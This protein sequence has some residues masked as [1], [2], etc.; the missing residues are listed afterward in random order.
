MK[1]GIITD[2]HSNIQA[3]NAVLNEFDKIKV[4]KIICCG[5]IIGIGINPE[6]TVQTLMKKKDM[7]IMVVG[8]HE[9]YL[10]NGLPETVHDDKRKLSDEEIANHLWNEGKLSEESKRF[11]S[12]LDL[13]K[14]VEIEGKKFY[15]VHYPMNDDGTYKKLIKEPSIMENKEM[16]K[17]IDA[18]VFLYGH[19]HKTSVNSDGNK[20]YINTG[21][22]GCPMDTNLAK[23][24]LLEIND[25]E[26]EFN[27]INVKYNVN[28]I[29]EEI[30]ELKFPFYKKILQIFYGEK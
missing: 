9:Q 2:I 14:S 7:L 22:L 10:L 18:D 15:I 3:L 29:I 28:K 11:L 19:T 21:A 30:N 25:G 12:E 16:F 6:E 26:I 1:I 4:D 13:S 23:A 5:D 27:I 20:W 8:N 24:G 17:E